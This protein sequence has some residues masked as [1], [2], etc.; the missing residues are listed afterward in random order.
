MLRALVI[1]AAFAV[2]VPPSAYALDAA[3]VNSADFAKQP[4][5]KAGDA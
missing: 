5:K 1:A 3:A 2:S 4:K